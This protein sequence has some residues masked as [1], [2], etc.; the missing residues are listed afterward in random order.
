MHNTEVPHYLH[1]GGYVLPGSCF[2]VVVGLFVCVLISTSCN[3]YDQISMKI[4][5]KMY[6]WTKKIPFTFRSHT[7]LDHEDAKTKLKNFNSRIALGCNGL[8]LFRADNFTV[9][10]LPINSPSHNKSLNHQHC[11]IGNF[12]TILPW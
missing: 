7:F 9:P 2:F 11:K 5:T 3:N 10:E 12:S 4:L 6:L 8:K 1:Q